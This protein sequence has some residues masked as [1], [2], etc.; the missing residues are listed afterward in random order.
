MDVG[1]THHSAYI[2]YVLQ[3][4]YTWVRSA[5]LTASDI[6][7]AAGIQNISMFHGMHDGAYPTSPHFRSKQTEMHIVDSL[8][9]PDTTGLCTEL[10]LGK[11]CRDCLSATHE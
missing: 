10:K 6:V 9:N 3:L 7:I 8:C 4:R 11:A 5:K 2:L 1:I